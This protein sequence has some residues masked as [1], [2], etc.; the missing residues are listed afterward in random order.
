M[1][2]KDD[3][4]VLRAAASETQRHYRIGPCGRRPQKEKVGFNPLQ[5]RG[6][7]LEKQ[8]RNWSELN[9]KQLTEVMPGRPTI[10]EHR[11]PMVD[12]GHR[13]R[14]GG[15]YRLEPLGEHPI[16][17]ARHAAAE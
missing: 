6:V 2:G 3:R 12:K 14:I 17:N 9:V 7:P 16:P 10:V 1:A 5:E 15:E 13:E 11:L 8:F 4:G